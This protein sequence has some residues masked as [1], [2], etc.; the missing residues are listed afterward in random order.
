MN[1]K[2]KLIICQAIYSLVA[3]RVATKNPDNLRGQVDAEYKRLYE[4]TGAKSFDAKLNGEK[5]GTYSL[6]ISKPTDSK[7]KTDFVLVDAEAFKNWKDFGAVAHA[8]AS[9]DVNMEDVAAYH[10]GKTGELPPG[11]ELQEYIVAG[12]PGGEIERSTLKIDTEKVSE[13]LGNGLQEAALLLL[14]GGDDD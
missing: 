8:Y 3:E 14:K 13:V 1:D 4:E 12:N 11:C 5:V 2:E 9:E 6:T 7:P 10:F